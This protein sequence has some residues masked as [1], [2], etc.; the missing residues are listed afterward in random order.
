MGKDTYAVQ[1]SQQKEKKN[2]LKND[3]ILKIVLKEKFWRI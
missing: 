3:I 1:I 2:I